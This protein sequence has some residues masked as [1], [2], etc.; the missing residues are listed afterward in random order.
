M[1]IGDKPRPYAAIL[2]RCHT[3]EPRSECATE[4]AKTWT[5][6]YEEAR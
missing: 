4:Y 2:P 5:N 6:R 1:G 3:A